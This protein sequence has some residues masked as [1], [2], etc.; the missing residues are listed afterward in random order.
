VSINPVFQIPCDN[1]RASRSRFIAH[2][3]PSPIKQTTPFTHIPH[4]LR[5]DGVGFRQG[6]CSFAFKNR[7]TECTSQSAG[8]A[9]D[10]VLYRALWHSNQFTQWLGKHWGRGRGSDDS[11]RPSKTSGQRP[12]RAG[13]ANGCYF[14]NDPRIFSFRYFW[15]PERPEAGTSSVDWAQQS[16]FFIP[17]TERDYNARNVVSYES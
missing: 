9:T 11:S 2:V 17:R 7:I 14:K 16:S 3:C 5:Q 6:E 4:T 15:C 1:R 8:L 13:C 12:A 10:M